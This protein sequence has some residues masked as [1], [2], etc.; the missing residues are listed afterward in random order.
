MEMKIN[1]VAV[2]PFLI[3][4]FPPVLSIPIQAIFLPAPAPSFMFGL[5]P[6]SAVAS[7]SRGN[8]GRGSPKLMRHPEQDFSAQRPISNKQLIAARKRKHSGFGS[9]AQA[10]PVKYRPDQ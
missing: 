1:H 9:P 2:S 6:K 8:V 5:P 4:V 7:K 10:I 3:V